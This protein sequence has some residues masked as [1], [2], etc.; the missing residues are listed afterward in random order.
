MHKENNVQDLFVQ[1]RQQRL[2]LAQHISLGTS[3]IPKL[4]IPLL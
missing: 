1:E 4:D 2:G 3:Q